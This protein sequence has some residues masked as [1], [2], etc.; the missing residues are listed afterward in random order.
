MSG[1]PTRAAFNGQNL[2]V[3]LGI[4]TPSLHT[5]SLDMDCVP[6][7]YTVTTSR[8]RCGQPFRVCSVL[9]PEPLP[10][11]SS[12][13]GRHRI[14][15][16]I[17]GPWGSVSLSSHSFMTP[18]HRQDLACFFTWERI[19]IHFATLLRLYEKMFIGLPS[20]HSS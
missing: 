1:G 2:T 8:G 17:A 16:R 5:C 19:N 6:R 7:A 18:S 11:A 20:T 14:T 12:H 3:S 13:T 10:Q 9:S 4:C 15:V